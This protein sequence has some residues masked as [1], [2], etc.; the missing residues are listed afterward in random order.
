MKHS[1]FSRLKAFLPLLALLL[2]PLRTHAFDLADITGREGGDGGLVVI[3]EA[4][5]PDLATAFAETEHHLVLSLHTDP[6][7]AASMDQAYRDAGVHPIADARHWINPVALPLQDHAVNILILSEAR[8][9]TL[10]DD[11]IRRV[12]VPRHGFALVRMDNTW[13]EIRT[14]RPEGMD[15]WHGHHRDGSGNRASRDTVI[16]PPNS[17]QWIMGPRDVRRT[18]PHLI[19]ERV[20]LLGVDYRYGNRIQHHLGGNVPSL[21]VRDAFTGVGRWAIHN[22]MGRDQPWAI[23]SF[24]DGHHLYLPKSRSADLEIRNILT[25]EVINEDLSAV[26]WF[27][28]PGDHRR[29]HAV[30]H[31]L[32]SDAERFYQLDGG[33]KIRAFT[34]DGTE[35]LWEKELPEGQYADMGGTDGQHLIVVVSSTYDFPNN[36]QGTKG[37]NT[38][39]SLA[40]LGLDPA[41]GRELWRYNGVEGYPLRHIVVDQGIVLASSHLDAPG[42]ARDETPHPTRPSLR[43]VEE[44]ILVAIDVTNGVE[45]FR[46]TGRDGFRDMERL[47]LRQSHNVLP[48]R[49]IIN[50]E[51]EAFVVNPRTGETLHA[52]ID[53]GPPRNGWNAVTPNWIINNGLFVSHDGSERHDAANKISWPSYSGTGKPA[54]GLF[55][56]PPGMETINGARHLG[57]MLALARRSLPEPFGDETR[58]IRRGRIPGGVQEAAPADWPTFRGNAQ[59]GAWRP[60]NGPSALEK[61]WET[62][63]ELPAVDEGMRQAWVFNSNVFGRL[64]PPVAD[65]GGVLVADVDGQQLH[66]FSLRDGRKLWSLDLGA[67]VNAPPT[68]AGGVAFAGTADGSVHAIH[69]ESGE[70]IWTFLAARADRLIQVFHQIENSHPVLTSPILHDGTLYVAAG[71]HGRADDGIKVWALN[72]ADGSIRGRQTVTG[73]HPNDMMQWV[74]GKLRI[75]MTDLSLPNLEVHEADFSAT[76]AIRPDFGRKVGG[77]GWIRPAAFWRGYRLDGPGGDRTNGLFTQ[78]E[79]RFGTYH[80]GRF[81]NIDPQDFKT[82]GEGIPVEGIHYDHLAGGGRY[83][84]IAGR[85][86]EGSPAIRLA[87]IDTVDGRADTIDIPTVEGREQIVTDGIA[88]AHGH[89]I[90]TTTAGRVLA[91]RQP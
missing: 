88:I 22:D 15:I 29:F 61:A 14:P 39:I 69:L 66:R 59:R 26:T 49:V 38:N 60:V 21:F 87:V 77:A 80:H 41:T 79:D 55:Y 67:R 19:T 31:R 4:N 70:I 12:L 11:E 23:M 68:L 52:A 91:F 24:T 6:D 28:S 33:R 83:H 64:T 89:V 13:R 58:L 36:S 34:P 10:G 25:G 43:Q 85:K 84:Y 1:K 48:D 17:I 74:N 44:N 8:G 65:A 45:R 51:R 63:I 86:Y 56:I 72:P 20:H 71:R 57:E 62:T 16:A 5:A 3:L 78:V 54:N 76:S 37:N 35:R 82:G 30:S 7:Q 18:D 47:W 53:L 9:R 81:F 46:R 27:H 73:D 40:I 2:P 42:L 75:G 32:F 90:V 50:E